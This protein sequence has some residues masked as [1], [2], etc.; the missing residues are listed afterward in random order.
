MQQA[1]FYKDCKSTLQPGELLVTAD[2]SENHSFILQDAGQGF[3]WN[4]YQATIHPFVAYY[5]D[6]GELCHLSYV[7]ISDY[8][9]H[10]TVAVYL[11]QKWLIAYLRR[12][13]SSNP[14]KGYYFSDGAA[15]QYKFARISSTCAIM[16]K[17]LECMLNGIFLQPLMVAQ[18]KSCCKS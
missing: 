5:I 11:F 18:L 3:H 14:Q 6:S 4:N 9:Q 10:D 1:S 17:I 2:F 12:K 8:L 13:L 16:K 7:V 15:F